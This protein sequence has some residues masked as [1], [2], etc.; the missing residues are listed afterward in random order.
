IFEADER[1]ATD[2]Q[3]FFRVDLDVLLMWMFAPALRRHIA[4]GALENFQQRLLDAFTRDIARNANVI[5]LAANLV[6]L[7][8]INDSD[9]GALYVVVRVLEQ[10]KNYILDVLPHIARLRKSGG[11]GDAERNIKNT[12]KSLG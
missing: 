11:I 9:L 2:E 7:I 3:D 8:Y 4:N 6:D 1:A 10:A 5:G 12:C